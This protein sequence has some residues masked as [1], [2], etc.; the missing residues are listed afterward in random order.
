MMLMM[1]AIMSTGYAMAA[2]GPPPMPDIPALLC[3]IGLGVGST[4]IGTIAYLWVIETAGPSVMAR[5]NYFVP[6]CSVTLGAWLLKEALDW[7]VFVALIVI[8]LGVIVS[9]YGREP[10]TKAPSAPQTDC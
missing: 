8:L 6:V 4:A 9:R 7:R 2:V 3:V 5:V 1:G 10:K